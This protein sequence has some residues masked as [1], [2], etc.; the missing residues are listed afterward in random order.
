MMGGESQV[1]A[2]SAAGTMAVV[3][4]FPD[5]GPPRYLPISPWGA[6]PLV[7]ALGLLPAPPMAGKLAGIRRLYHHDPGLIAVGWWREFG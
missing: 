7:A 4:L 6:V 3:P 1:S 2:L 5:G